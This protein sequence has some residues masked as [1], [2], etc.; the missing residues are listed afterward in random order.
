MADPTRITSLDDPRVAEY[1]DVRDADLRGGGG[2]APA[3]P[4]GP[5]NK[6]FMAE[7]EPVIRRLI[8][9]QR[10]AIKSLLVSDERWESLRAG[11]PHAPD[12]M[13]CFAASGT[14]VYLADVLLIRE[15]A[16][17][18]HHGGALA[19][20]FRPS[21]SDLNPE[22]IVRHLAGLNHYAVL[23]CE[24]ITHVD[25]I[26]AMFRNAAALGAEAVILNSDCADPL[27]R[28]AIRVSMGQVFNVRWAIAEDL[29]MVMHTLRSRC[30]ATIVAAETHPAATP[31]T[32]FDFPSRCGIVLGGERHGIS[33][34]TIA[35]ADFVVEFPMARPG[36][37]LNVAVAAAL[38]IQ[39]WK[40]A[41][42]PG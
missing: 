3:G 28:K 10:Y 40:R 35:K 27:F 9:S 30:L 37:T 20:G 18:R 25:N 14:T 6:L 12:S 33:S 42:R 17:Y 34:D 41:S 15:I 16:G 38:M 39:E 29:A 13:S 21:N 7:S 31:V 4:L 11:L 8:E 23:L 22:H 32:E 2:L 24:G 5:S 26:G 19:V 36:A 1:R